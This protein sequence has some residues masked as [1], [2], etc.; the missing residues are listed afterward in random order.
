[1][2]G[3]V[4]RACGPLLNKERLNVN[5]FAW[6]DLYGELDWGEEWEKFGLC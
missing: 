2:K 3:L 6:N 5:L 4:D 1:M